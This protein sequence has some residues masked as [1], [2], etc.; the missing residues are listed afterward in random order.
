LTLI[1]KSSLQYDF[2]DIQDR[3][4]NKIK[5]KGFVAV[6]LII[7]EKSAESKLI[8]GE[9]VI[10]PI[11]PGKKEVNVRFFRT[12]VWIKIIYKLLK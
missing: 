10:K 6:P 11:L 3:P 1:T 2:F 4:K 7:P 5:F 9:V 8:F 12:L